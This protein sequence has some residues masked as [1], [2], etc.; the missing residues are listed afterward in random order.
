MPSEE[1]K[2]KGT[3]RHVQT[4]IKLIS[5]DM[6][7]HLILENTIEQNIWHRDYY[8]DASRL[9]LVYVQYK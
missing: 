7:V 4:M 2:R 6:L 9:E 1:A 8:H 3:A 5:A